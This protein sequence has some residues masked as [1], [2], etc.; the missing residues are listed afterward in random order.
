MNLSFSLAV[1]GAH[2]RGLP[3]NHQLLERGAIFVEETITAPIYRLYH[4]PSPA[5]GILPRPGMIRVS[6]GGA[7][8]ALEIW[9]MPAETFGCFLQGIVAPL[10]LGRVFLADGRQVCGF[11]CEGVAAETAV[12]ITSYGGWR[13]WLQ[14]QADEAPWD[15][16]AV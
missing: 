8:I 4:L 3:L 14:A 6:T 13:N 10:G 2:M 7:S 15:S 11:I 5:A 12:D 16:T 1:C 9:T